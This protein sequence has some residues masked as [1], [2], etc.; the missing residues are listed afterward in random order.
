M[1]Q[2]FYYNSFLGVYHLQE[3]YGSIDSPPD[4]MEDAGALEDPVEYDTEENILTP[5]QIK[6]SCTLFKARGKSKSTFKPSNFIEYD[7]LNTDDI[8]FCGI[9]LT[10][11]GFGTVFELDNGSERITSPYLSSGTV[12]WL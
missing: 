8:I 9:I 2:I 12:R 10:W 3:D 5:K 11:I 1:H 4:E 7:D 6:N